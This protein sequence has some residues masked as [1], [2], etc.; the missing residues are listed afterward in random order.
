VSAAAWRRGK[1]TGATETSTK[2]FTT[3]YFL[4]YS[5]EKL[6]QALGYITQAELYYGSKELN[7]ELW[8]RNYPFPH[9]RITAAS[10]M[11]RAFTNRAV[12]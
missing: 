5:I 4:L 12:A 9:F 1:R 11:M 3:P 7:V 6:D 8:K 2:N 10:K